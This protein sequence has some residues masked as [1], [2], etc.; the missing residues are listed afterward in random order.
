[1]AT[2]VASSRI[3]NASFFIEEGIAFITLSLMQFAMDV[4][5]SYGGV[6]NTD[7]VR[8]QRSSLKMQNTDST[9]IDSTIKNEWIGCDRTIGQ[10]AFEPL[11]LQMYKDNLPTTQ[12]TSKYASVCNKSN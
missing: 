4:H 9:G 3:M 2:F 12:C 11:A 7:A 6:G 1:V 8:T 10:C 5:A